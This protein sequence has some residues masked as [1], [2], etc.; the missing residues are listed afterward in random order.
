M[1]KWQDYEKRY[2]DARLRLRSVEAYYT[3]QLVKLKNQIDFM[4]EQISKPYFFDMNNDTN[5]P[6]NNV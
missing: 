5:N 1:N 6:K 2:E 3:L 4:L